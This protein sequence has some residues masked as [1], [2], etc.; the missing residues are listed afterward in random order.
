MNRNKELGR[1]RMD[2]KDTGINE[3]RGATTKG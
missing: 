2:N 1:K 3:T